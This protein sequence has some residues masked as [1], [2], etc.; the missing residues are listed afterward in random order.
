MYANLFTGDSSQNGSARSIFKP[1]IPLILKGED[2]MANK[3]SYGRHWAIAVLSFLLVF[4]AV[5]AIVTAYSTTSYYVMGNK[6][7]SE[8]YHDNRENT[9]GSSRDVFRSVL[10]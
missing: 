1:N 7:Y 8:R 10:L 3:T 4:F 9:C 6:Q 5:G 2:I